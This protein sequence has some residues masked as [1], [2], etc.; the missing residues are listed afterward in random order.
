MR[1]AGIIAGM[2]LAGGLGMGLVMALAGPAAA[3]PAEGA[4][5]T[6][7]DGQ[8]Q[9]GRVVVA[10]CGDALCGTLVS[11]HDRQGRRI[12]SS[13]TGQR[14]I[15]DMRPEGGGRYGGGKIFVPDQ[16]KTYDARMELTPA[17]LLVSGCVMFV[18]R[19]V[20]WTRPR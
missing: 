20:D 12:A 14:L 2:T 11:V 15:W 4:W 8:G 13:R 5:L 6:Q 19:S 17:G 9:F 7:R 1:R 16:N 10:P 18:C 3:D